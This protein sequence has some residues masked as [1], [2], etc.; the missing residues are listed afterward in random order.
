[1]NEVV[2]FSR[3]SRD[4]GDRQWGRMAGS[5]Y[6]A[7]TADWSEAIFEELG[8]E[9]IRR[10]YF[11]LPPQWTPVDWEFTATGG[12]RQLT[13]GSL[14]P[15]QRI[16]ADSGGDASSRRSGSARAPRR[17]SWAATS[18]ARR[19][20]CRPSWPPARWAIPPPG[21]E[22]PSARR[23]TA[24]P[25]SSASGATPETWRCGRAWAARGRRAPT[26]TARR[27]RSARRSRC[28]ASSWAGTTASGCA[29]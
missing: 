17:T 20:S 4:A 13:F 12:D 8:M 27:P 6:E 16:H 7:L 26:P 9:N 22:R 29:I 3:M 23:R 2:A 10:Q 19:S 18:G 1:M 25:C 11:D 15:S 14:L 5:P 24:R 28:P 21:R